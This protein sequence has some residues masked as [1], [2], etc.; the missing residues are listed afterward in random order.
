MRNTRI[1]VFSTV[2]LV[3]IGLYGIFWYA[4]YSSRVIPHVFLNDWSTYGW[5]D[6]S[7]KTTLGM[8]L[9]AFM[10]YLPFYLVSAIQFTSAFLLLN[11]YRKLIIFDLRPARYLMV[12]GVSL[13]LVL[14]MDGLI[15]AY[16]PVFFS[17]WNTLQPRLSP[18]FEYDAG[19]FSIAFAGLGFLLIGWITRE[20]LLLRREN[21]AFV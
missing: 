14:P 16:E 9:T 19:D 21:E 1:R 8:R 17:Q 5:A 13:A 4:E 12:L 20:G 15:V 6:D 18:Q 2:L 7:L 11:C 3:L 10:I